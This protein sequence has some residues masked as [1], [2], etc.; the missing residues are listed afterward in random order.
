MK[1]L[2][3]REILKKMQNGIEISK[4]PYKKISK[5]LGISENELFERL[6]MMKEKGIIKKFGA[7]LNHVNIGF[8]ANGM[9]VWKIPPNETENVGRILSAYDQ[10][11]H[12]YERVTI[13]DKWEYNIFAMTH[14][15][16]KIQLEELVKEICE[17]IKNYDYKIIYSTRE[18]KKTGVQIL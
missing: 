7:S 8:Q 2:D 17:K 11:T 1:P 16:T 5:E 9:V 18:F 12:C 6:E 3:D 14:C 4:E 10:I 15:K 13:P